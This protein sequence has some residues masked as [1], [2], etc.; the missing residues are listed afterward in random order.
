MWWP[1]KPQPPM[2]RILPIGVF[3]SDGIG[4]IVAV[5]VKNESWRWVRSRNPGF[6]SADY[7]RCASDLTPVRT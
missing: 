6:R 1:R 5:M 3:F 4:A 2:T 7:L